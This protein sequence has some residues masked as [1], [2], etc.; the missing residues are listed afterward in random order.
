MHY[1]IVLCFCFRVMKRF[2]ALYSVM[3]DGEVLRTLLNVLQMAT[4][5]LSPN[6]FPKH[7][8]KWR[9]FDRFQYSAVR[10]RISP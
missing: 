1:G 5:V 8:H 3:Q 6:G 2:V 10:A 7:Q 4:A 9:I